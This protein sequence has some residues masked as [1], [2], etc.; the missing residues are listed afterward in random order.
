MVTA[1]GAE[2]VE[3]EAAAAFAGEAL[4]AAPGGATDPGVRS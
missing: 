2:E 4:S 1:L 3:E